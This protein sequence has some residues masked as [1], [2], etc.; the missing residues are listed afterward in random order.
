MP[1]PTV[2]EFKTR[3]LSDPLERVVE[4]TVFLRE[5]PYAFQ[6]KPHL[7]KTLNQHLSTYLKLKE[8]NLTVVGSAKIGF[9]LDP[10]NFPNQ[11]SPGSDI[12]VLIVDERMF[13]TIWVSLLDWHYDRRFHGMN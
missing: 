3:L 9:S 11:Y 12:D 10:N 8:G 7:F 4:E 2:E 5:D 6:G 13:D 1:Y